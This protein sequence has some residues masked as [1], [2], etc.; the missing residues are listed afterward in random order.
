MNKVTFHVDLSKLK[1]A[2]C[3]NYLRSGPVFIQYTG[4]SVCSK[5]NNP[6]GVASFRNLLY[7]EIIKTALF[8]CRYASNG[9]PARLQ[10]TDTSHEAVCVFK[11]CKCPVFKCKWVGS[12]EEIFTHFFQSV[13][14]GHCAAVIVDGKFQF[15]KNGEIYKLIQVKKRNYVIW[16][17]AITQKICIEVI[18]LYKGHSV[19][20]KV[21]LFKPNARDNGE[22]L[23]KG[24]TRLLNDTKQEII[25]Y[26]KKLLTDIL[27]RSEMLECSINLLV[28]D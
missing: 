1:C 7:E 18:N 26:D 16:I 6:C 10:S 28:K 22:I 11:S 27:G 24:R 12:A 8:P 15:N 19:E 14:N 9:C 3:H 5:C 17:H 25:E 2:S 21:S 13:Q 4:N 20:Y 23:K